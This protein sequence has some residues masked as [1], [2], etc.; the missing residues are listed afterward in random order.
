MKKT[1]SNIFYNCCTQLLAIIVPLITSP[2]I[3]R[4][5]QPDRLG[6]YTYIDSVSQ[7]VLVIGSIGL[8]NYA[9]REISYVKDNRR[10]R[11]IIF[12]EILILRIIL[13]VV[14][15]I[16]YCLFMKNTRYEMFSIYQLIW[17]FGSF[18]DI[19][20]LFNGVEDFK[21]IVLRTFFV[22]VINVI[23]I[24][25]F[26]KTRDDLLLYIIIMSICQ[27]INSL[28]CYGNIKKLIMLPD[29]K[30][31]HIIRHIKPTLKIALPQIVTL[32]YYQ[33]DKV[34]L[35]FLLKDTATIAYYD[36]ADKI[37][38]I[39]VTAITAVSTVML[40]KSSKYYID[41]DKRGLEKSIQ[42]T[43][44]FSILL[45]MPMCFGL[46]SISYGFVPWFYGSDYLMVAPIIIA[47]CPVI[48]ARGLSSISNTQYLVPTKNTKYLTLS[49]VFSAFA[50][51]II[52]YLTIPLFG[53]YG[54]VLGTIVAEYSVTAIQ[55]YYMMKNIKIHNLFRNVIKYSFYG[56]IISVVSLYIWTLM[57]TH[58]Y[59]TILQIVVACLLYL[60]MLAITKDKL[61][62]R[63]IKCRNGEYNEE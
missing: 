42:M 13:L 61:I 28:L 31:L 50:N 7:I 38:K 32:I 9:I 43:I 12:F 49:S 10:E 40:P 63:H 39:P 22:K 20:W 60:V 53:V 57:G 17:F 36:Q 62:F 26:I 56:L 52:N 45:I 18:L 14:S 35:E 34:M 1:I 11:S 33:M 51:V 29:F 47:L 4:V 16:A 54:A 2:Y 19:A 21:T 37:V 23:L 6:V 58:I 5:L 27:V 3:S 59:T 25:I 30:D 44:D 24:F 46:M 55:F 15:Y 41:D 48:I 8:S